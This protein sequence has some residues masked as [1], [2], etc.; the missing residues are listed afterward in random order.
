MTLEEF[1][2]HIGKIRQQKQ[3]FLNDIYIWSTLVFQAL[4]DSLSN[5]E[6]LNTKKFRVPSRIPSKEI[7]RTPEQVDKII[8]NAKDKDLYHALFTFIIAQVESFMNDIISLCLQFDNRRLKATIPSIN[9]TKKIDV[10]EIID[11]N[12]KDDIISLLIEKELTA[13]FYA[14]PHKQ[15]EYFEQVLGVKLEEKLWNS[16]IENKATRDLILHNQC[17][18]NEIYISKTGTFARGKIGELITVNQDYFNKSLANLKSII[19]KISSTIQ[20]DFRNV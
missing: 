13:I 19:G 17:E 7:R 6:F 12:C 20:K 2:E 16:W 15:K 3:K 14:S 10:S 9:H 18:I 5:D 1:K 8:R 4:D 11:C